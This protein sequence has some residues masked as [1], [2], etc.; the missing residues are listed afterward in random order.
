MKLIARLTPV[1]GAAATGLTL[2]ERTRTL[3]VRNELSA[4]VRFA[5]GNRPAS[6]THADFTVGA[7]ST[8][9][10][11]MLDGLRT[12]SAMVDYQGAPVPASDAGLVC[13]VGATAAVVV[14]TETLAGRVQGLGTPGT[15]SGGVVTVQGTVVPNTIQS[16]INTGVIPIGG[17]DP[18]SSKFGVLETATSDGLPSLSPNGGAPSILP[19]FTACIYNGSLWDRLR[20]PAIFKTVAAVAVTAG[21]PVS[22]WTPASGKSFRFMGGCVSLS[23][24][25]SI[26]FK[27]GATAGSATEIWRTPTLVAGSPYNIPEN[28]GNGILS[29][30]AN[31]QLWIDVTAS[32]TV[33][34]G[35]FGTEE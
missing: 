25:G 11:P 6:A 22:I 13:L 12:I 23:V 8:E 20:T 4:V 24:A 27:D 21:T 17:W 16:T 26:I 5:I 33:N 19:A 1:D 35:V 30:A 18:V 32:G 10:V 14:T 3:I 31:N 29:A 34:G 15:P 7:Y 9:A 28:I 2:P